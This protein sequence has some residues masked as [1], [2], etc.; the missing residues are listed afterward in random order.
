MHYRL[1][2]ELWQEAKV[3]KILTYSVDHQTD[4]LDGSKSQLTASSTPH[5]THL[6]L[7]DLITAYSTTASVYKMTPILAEVHSTYL[8]SLCSQKNITEVTH[9]IPN[10]SRHPN[11]CALCSRS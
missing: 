3:L 5:L 9:F 7:E 10:A 6:I 8:V 2:N 1:W 4:N 11:R